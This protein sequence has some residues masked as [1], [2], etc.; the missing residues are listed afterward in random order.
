LARPTTPSVRCRSCRPKQSGDTFERC[1]ERTRATAAYL[2]RLDGSGLQLVA[3]V[4][5]LAAPPKLVGEIWSL[6]DAEDQA[7]SLEGM[8][9]LPVPVYTIHVLTAQEG[10]AGP[11]IVGA[12][13]LGSAGSRVS[14]TSDMISEIGTC[15]GQGQA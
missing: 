3:H 1:I 13:A 8:D 4:G 11:S 6:I 10:T 7:T 9:P 5:P 12:L 14:L 2:Y 15:L